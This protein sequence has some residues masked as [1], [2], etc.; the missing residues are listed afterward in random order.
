M[1]EVVLRRLFRH[2]TFAEG[3]AAVWSALSAVSVGLVVPLLVIPK[4]EEL[5][6]P[7]VLIGDHVGRV[8]HPWLGHFTGLT[9]LTMLG[10]ALFWPMRQEVA[11][12]LMVLSLVL[13]LGVG[14][15]TSWALNGVLS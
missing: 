1:S 15:Y 14:F 12:F 5:F 9:C 2:L 10:L 13:S 4:V 7:E 8:L 6:S 3:V 11:R